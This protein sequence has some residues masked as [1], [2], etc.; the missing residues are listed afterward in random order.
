ML[1]GLSLE[2]AQFSMIITILA[3]NVIRL[4]WLLFSFRSWI[5]PSLLALFFILRTVFD[6]SQSN[7]NRTQASR[8]PRPSL[9]HVDYYVDNFNRWHTF[10]GPNSHFT[11][12]VLNSLC[13]YSNLLHWADNGNT[14][15]SY[16][17]PRVC[18]LIHTSI[19]NLDISF[20]FFIPITGLSRSESGLLDSM[21]DDMLQWC[22]VFMNVEGIGLLDGGL[23]ELPCCGPV[24]VWS[25]CH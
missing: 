23:M 15:N 21:S 5:W 10:N 16:R 9:R 8:R 7:I 17:L 25:H 1:I 2:L 22:H 19:L 4:S 13:R 14:N 18:F 20:F 6:L 24:V 12:R 11:L 3:Q